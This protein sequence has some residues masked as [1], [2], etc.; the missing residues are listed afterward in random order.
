MNLCINAR[1]ALGTSGRLAVSLSLQETHETC[2]VCGERLRGAAAVLSVR[3]NG[4]GVDPAALPYIFEPFYST[5]TEQQ[6]TDKGSMALAI[7]QAKSNRN[8]CGLIN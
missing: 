5:K 7:C 1:D 3:D 4:A 8:C 6:G 2:V